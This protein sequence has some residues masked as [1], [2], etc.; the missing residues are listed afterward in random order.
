MQHGYVG[1][2]SHLPKT[3]QPTSENLLRHFKKY[4]LDNT[5]QKHN[6]VYRSYK[7][8]ST[9]ALVEV[10]RAYLAEDAFVF[11]VGA[12]GFASWEEAA[13][14]DWSDSRSTT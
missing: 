6:N 11:L 3:Q 9:D 7:A 4:G 14:N 12:I 1:D 8:L 2:A 10:A 5:H 13:R